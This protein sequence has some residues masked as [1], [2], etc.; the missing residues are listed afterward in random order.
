MNKQF[1]IIKR[2]LEKYGKIFDMNPMEFSYALQSIINDDLSS[3]EIQDI[4]EF[5]KTEYV[6]KTGSLQDLLNDLED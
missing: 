1:K 3:S 6:H 5:R 4:M 2:Y